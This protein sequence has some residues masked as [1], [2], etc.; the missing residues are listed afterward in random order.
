MSDL[1]FSCPACSKPLVVEEIAAGT[2]ILCPLCDTEINVPEVKTARLLEQTPETDARAVSEVRM[3]SRIT[4]ILYDLREAGESLI[5]KARE[6]DRQ[7]GLIEGA[8]AVSRERLM[9]FERHLEP[10]HFKQNPSESVQIPESWTPVPKEGRWKALSI[11][12]G[13]LAFVLALS[14]AMCSP[15]LGG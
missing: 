10:M 4:D 8:L 5:R 15:V 1:Y 9:V 13:L 3:E 12:F 6:Q 2:R 14:L 11:G 7:L